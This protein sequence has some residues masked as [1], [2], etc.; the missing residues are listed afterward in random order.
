MIDALH[1]RID[2]LLADQPHVLLAIDGGSASGK[3]TMAERLREHYDANVIPMDHFFL[4]PQQRTPERLAEPGG[5][6]DYA[7]F[8]V[9]VLTP[10]KAGEAFTYRLF[11][12]QIGDFGPEITI[13]PRQLN[14]IEGAYSLHPTL[15]DAYHMKVFLTVDPA[16]QVRR[17]L[18]RNGAEMLERFRDEWIPMEKRYFAH[19]DIESQCDF[20]R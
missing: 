4:R 11:D 3:S 12:C 18:G 7:R 5:N 2:E 15:A 8:L 9:E 1:A 10:L 20:V 16:E 17:I 19:F 14:V 13:P 6:V